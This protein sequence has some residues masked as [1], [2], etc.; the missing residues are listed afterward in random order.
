MTRAQ[1]RLSG[2]IVGLGSL[3][4]MI[5]LHDTHPFEAGIAAGVSMIVNAVVFWDCTR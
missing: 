2:L 4:L 1:Y 3:G 5:A